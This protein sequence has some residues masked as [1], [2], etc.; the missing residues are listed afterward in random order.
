MHRLSEP[1]ELFVKQPHHACIYVCCRYID[2]SIRKA[3]LAS[4]SQFEMLHHSTL[5]KEAVHLDVI[6]I[7]FQED[8]PNRAEQVS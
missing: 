2:A 4:V 6:T 3:G 7:C 8:V 1:T 5:Q